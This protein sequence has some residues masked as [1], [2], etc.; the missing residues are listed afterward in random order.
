MEKTEIF[1]YEP[2]ERN[3]LPVI[4]MTPDHRIVISVASVASI[5][6][7]VEDWRGT[8]VEY[9]IGVVYYK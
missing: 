8:P 5:Y 7:K 3:P 2:D 6:F 9:N 1:K 4:S